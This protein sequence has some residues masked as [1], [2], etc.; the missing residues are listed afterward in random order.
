M[1]N[2]EVK[3][4]AIV[5]VHDEGF[6]AW[7]SMRSAW[8]ALLKL[9]SGELLIVVDRGDRDTQSCANDFVESCAGNPKHRARF[10]EVDNGDLGASR[11]DGVKMA[12]GEFVAFLDADDVWCE[13]WL[14]KGIAY[15]DTV[16]GNAVAH[17]QVN[18]NF[19]ADQMW[20]Q[21][22]DSRDPSFD[23][24]TFMVTNHWTA[25][26]LAPRWF[27]DKHPYRAA[28]GGFGFEDWEWN[29]RTLADGIA[30]VVVPETVHFIR[31]SP[32]SMTNR[33]AALGSV[34]RPNEF[35]DKPYVPL[36]GLGEPAALAL[37]E[38]LTDA[39]KKAHQIEPELWPGQ[40]E[41][42]QRQRYFAPSAPQL[43]D[44]YQRIRATIPA[45]ATHAVFFA[46][47]GGGADLRVEKYADAIV[48][49][50]GKPALIATDARSH[51]FPKHDTIEVSQA[52]GALDPGGRSRV[53]QRLMLQLAARG[54]TL[55]IVNSQAAWFAV[56]QNTDV[57]KKTV[58]ASL[59]AY[60]HNPTGALGGYVA[61]GA[62]SASM[63][64]VKSV[65]TDNDVFRREVRERL[66]WPYTIVAPTP[67]A[68][69]G[70]LKPKKREDG[71]P[72]RVL[73]AGRADWNKNLDFVFTIASH[74]LTA[75]EKVMFDVVGES[76]DYHGFTALSKLKALPNVKLRPSYQAF[77]QLKP[78]AFDVF[79]L[80]SHNEGMPNTVLEAMAHGL[81]V[82]CSPAGGLK[83]CAVGEWPGRV[84]K[85]EDPAEW[86]KHIKQA[87]DGGLNPHLWL[88]KKHTQA[89]FEAALRGSGYLASRL[90]VAPKPPDEQPRAQSAQDAPSDAQPSAQA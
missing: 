78:E 17:P 68:P 49:S 84:V 12:S 57:F 66:G 31:R 44:V 89:A 6:L 85:G 87:A 83:D 24:S 15:L 20:W 51:G 62:F 21:H 63:K 26:A 9:P 55:H 48:A 64:A 14:E 33:H 79:L 27:F 70:E 18:V 4:T 28:G 42:V 22:I 25:L 50:G 72:I 65:F 16:P 1:G 73:V 56:A 69:V 36:Q 61:N 46:G 8:E 77:A 88:R 34:T 43:F 19:E 53:V 90:K 29:M 10:F 38:W 13:D 60:E 3:A 58:Y 80:T 41:L 23:P 86:V 35:F 39:W 52:L 76:S 5:T 54:V 40:R 47:L 11:N 75:G 59:Y 74:C 67:F 2:E 7:R 82:V 81:P 71:H 30:H 37:G 45:D 32:K